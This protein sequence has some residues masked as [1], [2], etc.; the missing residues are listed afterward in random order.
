MGDKIKVL[1]AIS[2]NEEAKLVAE[3]VFEHKMLHHAYNKDFAVLYRTN[4]QSRA[5]EE[6]FRRANIGY[7]IVGGMS[8]YQRKEIKDL[9]AY[10]RLTVN[11]N[12]EEALKR[13]INYPARGI[14]DTTMSY[15]ISIAG[16]KIYLYGKYYKRPKTMPT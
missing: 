6:A 9:L 4:S 15:I 1:R 12:D 7:K 8:F 2:D 11:P 10:Y 13:V 14:G 3:N 16:A 5:L